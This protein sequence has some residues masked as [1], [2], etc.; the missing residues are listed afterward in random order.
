[1]AKLL[2]YPHYTPDASELRGYLLFYD[3]VSTIVPHCDQNGV[4]NRADNTR[5]AEASNGT[6]IGFF[7]PNPVNSRWVSDDACRKAL[8][9][10]IRSRRDKKKNQ[11]AAKIVK[12]NEWGY[13]KS[14]LVDEDVHLTLRKKYGWRHFA[15]QKLDS[16]VVERLIKKKLAC[17]VNSIETEEKP[18]LMD[19]RIGDFIVS[20][21]A[22]DLS[23]DHGL[24]A[25]SSLKTN[26][27]NFLIDEAISK[28]GRRASMITLALD[29]AIPK[30]LDELPF[31]EYWDLR[32][33]FTEVR[34]SVGKISDELLVQYDLDSESRALQ[35]KERLL[36]RTS[37]LSCRVKTAQRSGRKR[38]MT[39]LT[40][41]M[42][43][44]GVG[45]AVG[46]AAG[47]MGGAFVAGAIAP[48]ITKTGGDLSTRLNPVD[49]NAIEQLAVVRS[50]VQKKQRGLITREMPKYIV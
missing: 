8:K 33:S 2:S 1:M 49:I 50:G 37:D 31:D 17:K 23:A 38:K 48:V 39:S 9:K 19:P 25:V 16:K 22:R 6:A 32:Q 10:L 43:F 20:R 5:I 11:R 36:D 15:L 44:S 46:Y 7:D 28:R 47:G 29:I 34:A 40:L 13:L 18:V 30:N 41:D 12:T 24:A 26:T 14:K 3:K 45:A 42:F 4:K 21:I 27:K 35:F